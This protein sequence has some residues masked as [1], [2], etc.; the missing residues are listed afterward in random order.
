MV[1]SERE[2]Y[3]TSSALT[4][5]NKR[6]TFTKSKF[7]GLT[8]LLF[9]FLVHSSWS[10][11]Y[12]PLGERG[13]RV[14]GMGLCHSCS[15]QPNSLQLNQQSL[16]LCAYILHLSPPFPHKWKNLLRIFLCPQFVPNPKLVWLIWPLLRLLYP[17]CPKLTASHQ[18]HSKI[19][20][21]WYPVIGS[22]WW[23]LL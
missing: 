3:T 4:L 1:I 21:G 19:S 11:H 6:F 2:I 14:D 5:Q 17:F 7:R 18:S 15:Q 16:Y 13:S 23:I 9:L 8:S 22:D 10:L 12:L 20:V